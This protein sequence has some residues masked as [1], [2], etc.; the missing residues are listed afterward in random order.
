MKQTILFSNG[1]HSETIFYTEKPVINIRTS[2]FVTNDGNWFNRLYSASLV[3]KVQYLNKDDEELGCFED[4]TINFGIYISKDHKIPDLTIN[5]TI[6]TPIQAQND[7]NFL[8][9]WKVSIELRNLHLEND[10][11]IE[12][13][14]MDKEYIQTRVDDWETRIKN[15]YGEIQTWLFNQQGYKTREGTPVLM[16]EGMMK[17]FDVSMKKIPT[18][19]ILLDNTLKLSFKPKGLWIMGANGR[20]DILSLNIGGLLLIDKAESLKSPQWFL[21]DSNRQQV[22]WSKSVFLNLIYS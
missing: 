17:T 10:E 18:L 9:K 1:T 8:N 16:H 6:H 15:L 5:K 7:P 11:R 3:I 22:Q 2:S 14:I 4:P 13:L 21:V 20:V 12:I 19:D